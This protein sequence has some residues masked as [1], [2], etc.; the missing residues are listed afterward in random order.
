MSRRLSFLLCNIIGNIS[1]ADKEAQV[2][3]CYSGLFDKRQYH[4]LQFIGCAKLAF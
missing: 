3:V 2:L 4:R 1:T